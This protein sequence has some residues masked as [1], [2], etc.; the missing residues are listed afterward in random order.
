MAVCLLLMHQLTMYHYLLAEHLTMNICP[1]QNRVTL[2]FVGK[3]R[4]RY[5]LSTSNEGINACL[6]C[7]YR[8]F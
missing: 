7:C 5:T 8:V 4:L 2:Q 6:G 3:F 1:F